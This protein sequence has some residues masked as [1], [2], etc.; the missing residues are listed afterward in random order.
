MSSPPGRGISSDADAHY[1]N[2]GPPGAVDGTNGRRRAADMN[3]TVIATV[4]SI[5]RRV[6]PF[7]LLVNH[8]RSDT[9]D[10]EDP[11][12]LRAPPYARPQPAIRRRAQLPGHH[13]SG[14]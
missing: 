13:E 10:T 12:V 14:D 3:L 8:G 7:G 2:T 1:P 6:R 11:R 9:Q 5:L 4:R